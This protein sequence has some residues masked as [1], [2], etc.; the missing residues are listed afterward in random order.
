M[1]QTKAIVDKLLTNVS[2]AY[3]PTGYVSESVFAQIPVKQ[4]SGKLGKYSNSHIR[5]QNT[6]M[7]GRGKARRVEIITRTDTNYNIERHGLEGLVTK[8]DEINVE[9]PFDAQKDEVI[10]LSTA[11]WLGKE[12]SLGD[13]LT[14][15]AII[16]Q[17]VTL[18]GTDQY[19]DFTNSDPIGDFLTA[20][21][22][23]RSAS[24]M[25]PDTAVM[26]WAVANTLSYSPKILAALGY[27]AN[28]AGQLSDQELA[29][30]MG[31]QRLLIAMPSFNNSKEGQADSLTPVWGKHVV[32]MVAPTKA[33]PYQVSAGYY[34][35][36]I[37]E[38]P[39]Q[40]FKFPINNPPES[41]GVIVRDSFDYLLSNTAAAYLIEDAIA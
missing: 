13:T 2:S 19:N 11:I 9:K 5:I 38:S 35:T 1:A 39:R 4:T 21:L 27:T 15:P 14:D 23:V 12:K 10:G 24:G 18:S 37:G 32:F 6:V 34:L 3:I 28:R 16:T 30:A 41:T 20:R 25:P 17:K 40:V 29:K 7:G 31:V 33:V 36:L 22:T 26:D 8:D